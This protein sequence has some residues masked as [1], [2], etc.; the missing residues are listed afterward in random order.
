ME[1]L[2]VKHKLVHPVHGHTGEHSSSVFTRLMTS[3]C[4]SLRER[5]SKQQRDSALDITVT[6]SPPR[7]WSRQTSGLI[8]LKEK[9]RTVDSDPAALPGGGSSSGLMIRLEMQLHKGWVWVRWCL[10]SPIWCTTYFAKVHLQAA[11]LDTRQCTM[12]RMNCLMLC[13]PQTPISRNTYTYNT[14][15]HRHTAWACVFLCFIV[16]HTP[17]KVTVRGLALWPSG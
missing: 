1:Y 17:Q 12:K 2:R 11:E 14:H 10:A 9:D 3:R 6:S 15:T 4:F 13:R 7:N 5:T 16:C 8:L